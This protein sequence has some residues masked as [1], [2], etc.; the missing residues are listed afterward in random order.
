M[1]PIFFVLFGGVGLMI[2]GKAFS[3]KRNKLNR[4][5]AQL[6]PRRLSEFE[7][8]LEAVVDPPAPPE[9]HIEPVFK[10]PIPINL[11]GFCEIT[12]PY[13]NFFLKLPYPSLA[14]S[15]AYVVSRIKPL[16][17][18]A[19]E[20]DLDVEI[21]GHNTLRIHHFL[22]WEN[23]STQGALVFC[24]IDLRVEVDEDAR[25]TAG[26]RTS[27]DVF[28]EIRV[29]TFEGDSI[30]LYTRL[31]DEKPI[32]SITSAKKCIRDYI[33]ALNVAANR[34]DLRIPVT[35]HCELPEIQ[36]VSERD[37]FTVKRID[38]EGKIEMYDICDVRVGIYSLMRGSGAPK[39][40]ESGIKW[41]TAYS[42]QKCGYV[43]L[44]VSSIKSISPEI[45]KYLEA[46]E[47][48]LLG[49]ATR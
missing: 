24:E 46:T 19:Q 47:K 15:E 13:Q 44:K 20:Y 9:T 11:D 21:K 22:R 30:D 8:P 5:K 6:T 25:D 42:K 35:C 26:N 39:L 48:A 7:W 34:P 29:E 4:A 12:T 43:D 49:P 1:G 10:K 18:L 45:C 27:Y 28:S 3:R 31:S 40:R 14:R 17:E 16:I 37:K 2:F 41:I 38:F 36:G 32:R 33:K 23:F